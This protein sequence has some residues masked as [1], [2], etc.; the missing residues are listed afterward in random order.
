MKKNYIILPLYNDWV[1]LKKVLDIL[2]NTLK[3]TNNNHIIIVNDCS[4]ITHKK[5]LNILILKV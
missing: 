5:K 3:N 2:N 4:T 1:S